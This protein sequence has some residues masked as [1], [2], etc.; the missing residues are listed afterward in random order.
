MTTFLYDEAVP[1]LLKSLIEFF[2]YL[3]RNIRKMCDV[4]I[5]EG[6]QRSYD[7]MLNFVLRHIRSLDQNPLVRVLA[8]YL[9]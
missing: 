3:A 9:E 4:M 7:R 2:F 8:E 5:F 6:S 1:I